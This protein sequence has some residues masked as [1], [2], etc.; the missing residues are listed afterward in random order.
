MNSIALS[1]AGAL[2]LI[3]MRG[4]LGPGAHACVMCGKRVRHADDCPRSR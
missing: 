1:I 3:V 2:L 4:T